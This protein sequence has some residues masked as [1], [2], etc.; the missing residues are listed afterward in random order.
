MVALYRGRSMSQWSATMN[1]KNVKE[2]AGIVNS[3]LVI[4]KAEPVNV[5]DNGIYFERAQAYWQELVEHYEYDLDRPF[6]VETKFQAILG[7]PDSAT[8]LDLVK[9]AQDA[10]LLSVLAAWAAGRIDGPTNER[11]LEKR[12]KRA[13]SLANMLDRKGQLDAADR[14]RERAD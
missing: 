6:H 8:A 7:A 1:K 14:Q 2:K 12:I 5:N 4:V 10:A 11:T 9:K 13:E 3:P